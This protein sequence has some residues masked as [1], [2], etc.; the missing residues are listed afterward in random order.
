MNNS[1]NNLPI[2][3]WRTNLEIQEKNLNSKKKWG[4]AEFEV[5]KKFG[6]DEDKNGEERT[7]RREGKDAEFFL[8]FSF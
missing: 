5:M 8:N 4:D 1:Q 3:T 2:K 7:G 6:E